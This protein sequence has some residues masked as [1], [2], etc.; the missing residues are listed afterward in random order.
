MNDYWMGPIFEVGASSAG[1]R[2]ITGAQ[3][4]EP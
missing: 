1:H 2:T 4:V 3:T